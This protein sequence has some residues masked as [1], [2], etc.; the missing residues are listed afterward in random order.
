MSSAVVARHRRSIAPAV[1]PLA[2]IAG[3]PTAT[4]RAVLSKCRSY[5]VW[6]GY[7]A[8]SKRSCL[9]L[10]AGYAGKARFVGILAY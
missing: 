7:V 5:A 1:L 6:D 2:C 3:T 9:L 10:L 4:S 8:G